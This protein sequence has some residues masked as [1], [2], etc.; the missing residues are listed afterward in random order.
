[1]ILFERQLKEHRRK[2]KKNTA[3]TPR[4]KPFEKNE[5]YH[6]LYA[7]LVD[8]SIRQN[9]KK[10][11][12]WYY[13]DQLEYIEGLVKSVSENAEFKLETRKNKIVSFM[14]VDTVNNSV[15]FTG[16]FI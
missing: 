6:P 10:H 12:F 5:W 7:S 11:K 3:Q 14:V 1:M 13:T 15:R 2:I 9:N 4:K 8:I 16:F